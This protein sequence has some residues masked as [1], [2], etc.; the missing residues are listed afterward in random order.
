MELLSTI[1]LLIYVTD[2]SPI[3]LVA[4]EL[5]HL[6]VQASKHYIQGKFPSKLY[7]RILMSNR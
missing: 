3:R 5:M 7:Q 6:A 1:L 2:D 4:C